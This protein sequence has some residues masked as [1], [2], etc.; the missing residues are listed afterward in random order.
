MDLLLDPLTNDLVFVNGK[1][2]VTRTQSE[3]VAQRLKITLYTFLGEWFLDTT[4]GVPY[5]QQIF[6]KNRSKN[7]VDVIFQNII[8]ADPG[9]IEIREFE[10][11]MDNTRGY[12]MTFSVRVAGNA[13]T[14]VNISL[15]L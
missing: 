13:I 1:T 12:E 10:S 14:T 5:F 2:T 4:L 8:A 9:V 15:G 7:A 6:G 3:I 11:T